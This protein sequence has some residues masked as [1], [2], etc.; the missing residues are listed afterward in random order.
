MPTHITKFISLIKSPKTLAWI[1]AFFICFLVTLIN[2]NYRQGISGRI[3]EFEVGRVADRDIFANTSI[4]YIDERATQIMLEAQERLV[5]AVFQFS[6]SVTDEQINRWN[7]FVMLAESISAGDI[8]GEAFRIAVNESFPGYFTPEIL[9]LFVQN[10]NRAELLSES[11]VIFTELLERGIFS[12]PDTGMERSN[13]YILELIKNTGTRIER[14]RIQ[15]ANIIT[16]ENV[17]DAILNRIAS[18]SFS[19]MLT[20]F[21]PYL[22]GP[23]LTENVFYSP[24]ET[25][26]MLNEARVN[27]EPVMRFIEQGRQI[28]KR[29][30]IITEEEM[31][32]LE[33]VRSSMP[34]NNLPDIFANLLF[35]LLIF[36]F[37]IFFCGSRIIGRE[38]IE[39]EVYL[40]AGLTVLYIAGSVFLHY[41]SDPSVPVAVLAPTALVIILLSILISPRFALILAITLPMGAFLTGTFDIASYL[42][43]VNSGVIAAYSLHGAEKRKDLVKAGLIIAAANLAA[44]TAI[45][46]WQHI[47]GSVYPRALL[48]AAINGIVTGMLVLGILTPLE[49]LMNAATSFRLIELSDLNVPVLRR[50]FT[51]APGTYSHSIM[52]ANLAETACQDIGANSL[53]ARVGAYYHDL[54]KMENPEFFVENQKNHNVHDEMEP[55]HSAAVIRRHVQLGIEK[56]RQLKLPKDVIDIIGEHHGNSIIAW[57]Y[58]KALKQGEEEKSTIN[59][60]DYRYP[61]NPPRSRESTV[62]MLAD[63]AEAAVRS[64]N[65][66]SQEEIEKFIDELFL[67]RMERGEFS[68]AELTFTDLEKIKNAFVR[69]LSG[70]YHTR[71]EYPKIDLSRETGNEQG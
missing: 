24:V 5:P 28:I 25:A 3:D 13:P 29:G 10:Q 69:V 50:L 30:F 36:G 26:L 42:F 64:L 65:K 39:A 19:P 44:M 51:S 56:A 48:W 68:K 23:F 60:A 38:L 12:L 55:K 43:A 6:V 37:L 21:A 34:E 61:G 40:T 71:I 49:Q 4:A 70:Y 46:L 16:R 45:L 14:E 41:V 66:P 31:A 62:V 7:R 47:P 63:I 58:N 15:N 59:I 53:L 57:F 27:T 32:E 20:F 67:R 22:I 33:I 18:G 2:I 1:A 9:E 35:L 8:S 17:S 54:G 52:V 11:S